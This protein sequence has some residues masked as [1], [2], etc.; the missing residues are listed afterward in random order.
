M[1][2]EGHIHVTSIS[3]CNHGITNGVSD[4]VTRLV[5]NFQTRNLLLLPSAKI[6]NNTHQRL[7][8]RELL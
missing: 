1:I 4:K 6:K 8:Q 2:L 7:S 5:C 3:I